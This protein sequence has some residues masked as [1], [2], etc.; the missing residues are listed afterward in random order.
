[1]GRP[2]KGLEARTFTL[3]VKISQSEFLLWKRRAR[4]EGQSLSAWLLE[5]RRRE[6]EP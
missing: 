1:M 6:S 2:T 4:A 5:P 3:A